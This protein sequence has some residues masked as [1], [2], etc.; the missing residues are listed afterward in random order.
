VP[1]SYV[2]AVQDRRK[3]RDLD[4]GISD[5]D[6]AATVEASSQSVDVGLPDDADEALRS[7]MPLGEL[8][9]RAAMQMCA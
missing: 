3:A 7:T 1:Q 5:P 6:F 4:A 9:P 2:P 8:M